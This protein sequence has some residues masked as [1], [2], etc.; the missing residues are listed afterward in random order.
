VLESSDQGRRVLIKGIEDEAR[1]EADRIVQEAQ[2]T[3]EQRRKTAQERAESILREA[4]DK[5]KQ[6]ADRIKKHTDSRISAE[7]RRI[8]LQRQEEFLQETLT[9]VSRRLEERMERPGYREVLVGWIVEAAIGLNVKEAQVIASK[10]E[11]RFLDS[12]LLK[13]AAQELE[14][15]TGRKIDLKVADREPLLLQGV[16]VYAREGKLV[17][18]NRVQT[19]LLRYRSEIRRVVYRELSRMG[20]ETGND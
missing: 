14:A 16:V 2:K 15:L 1:E 13:R 18:D 6:Q 5:A 12:D 4:E 8:S 3:A 11:M 10:K 17:F 9:E 7:R 19:R 20:R